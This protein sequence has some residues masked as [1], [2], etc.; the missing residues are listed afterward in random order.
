MEDY[1]S[2][3]KT[4]ITLTMGIRRM[5]DL[6]ATEGGRMYVNNPHELAR[7]VESHA[8]G[9]LG[10][11]LMESSRAHKASN[12]VIGHFRNDFPE[13]DFAER[14]FQGFKYVDGARESVVRDIPTD[15]Y[16]RAPYAADP[17]ENYQKYKGE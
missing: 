16:L 2:A 15:W 4:D 9:E 14:K 6:L 8:L 12:H 3:Y 17:E 11:A 7:A 5:R 13:E 10:I 1:Y